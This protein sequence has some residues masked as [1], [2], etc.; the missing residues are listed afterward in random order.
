M[1]TTT[2]PPTLASG[3]D[4]WADQVVLY[5]NHHGTFVADVVVTPFA[6]IVTTKKQ[7]PVK[8]LNRTNVE[9]ANWHITEDLQEPGAYWNPSKGM[10]VLRRDAVTRLTDS[11]RKDFLC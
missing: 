9:R 2:T 5:C 10:F 7:R 4:C 6:V 1:P 8:D 11:N 3:P